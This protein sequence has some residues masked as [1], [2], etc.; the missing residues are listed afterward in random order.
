MRIDPDER[1]E[2]A[3]IPDLAFALLE[4]ANVS[5]TD[6]DTV[7]GH[8][9]IGACETSAGDGMWAVGGLR[10]GKKRAETRSG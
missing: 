7:R 10:Q 6:H 8:C 9:G 1:I 5:R 3:Y 4:L 2:S